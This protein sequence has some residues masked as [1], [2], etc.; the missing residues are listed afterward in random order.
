MFHMF[1]VEEVSQA[2][3]GKSE[4]QTIRPQHVRAGDARLQ[5]GSLKVG[6]F[7]LINE[8]LR[9]PG[10]IVVRASAREPRLPPILYLVR[11]QELAVHR[12]LANLF[13]IHRLGP[14]RPLM[15]VFD[16]GY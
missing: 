14:V 4:A 2:A 12:Q 16:S 9:E 1:R 10:T 8:P 11:N 3:R 5:C 13:A 6:E 7:V 15:F